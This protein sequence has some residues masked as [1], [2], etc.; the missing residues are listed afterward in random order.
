MSFLRVLACSIFIAALSG[1]GGGGG[2]G[3]GGGGGGNPSVVTGPTW[4]QGSF[5]P[6]STFE[7]RCAVVRTGNDSQGR[8]FPDQAGTLAQELFFLRSW[9]NQTYLW[10]TEVADQNPAGFSD[11]IA[12]FNVLKTNALASSGK[13]KDNFH[14]TLSTADYLA[15]ITSAPT[16]GYG[17][18]IRIFTG[19]PPRD[20]RVLYTQSGTPAAELLNGTPKLTRGA[21]ILTV[22]GI[23]LVNGGTTPAQ[24][25]ILNNGLFPRTAGENHTFTVRYPD[26]T[27][28]AI[29]LTSGSIVEAPV[30]RQTVLTTA[31]GKVGYILLNTFSPFS[32]EKALVDA[33]AALKA[34]G[35]NDVVLDLRYNGGGLLA[36]ASQLSYMVAGPGRTAGHVFERLQFNAAAGSTN[37][38]SGGANTPTPFFNTGIGFSVSDGAPIQTLDLPRV[39]IL[40]SPSTCSASESVINGLRGVDV[41]VVLIGGATCGKPYGFYAEDNCGQTYFSIQF[42]GINDKS[43]GDYPDGFAAQNSS[44][45]FAVKIPGCVVADDINHELG[46]PGEAMLAAAL[47][48][49]AGGACPAPPPTG[50]GVARAPDTGPSIATSGRSE[51][52]QVLRSIRDLSMPDR[53]G[54]GR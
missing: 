38:V 21:R 23:D 10:N 5:Q 30:N 44:A 40:S 9:T 46:D 1:C 6:A 45:S 33:I 2:G 42:K 47:N 50:I 14:F 35:V 26:N 25:D 41:D 18:E 19:S 15:Q 31:N 36:V 28:R 3:S 11:R 27:E 16:A 32:S 43:F 12:Y 8:P 22:D 48:H 24:I 20:A 37:P 4:T 53:S 13:P 29:T 7:N 52:A 34:Q 49:R 39:Y 54:A 17:A 51:A